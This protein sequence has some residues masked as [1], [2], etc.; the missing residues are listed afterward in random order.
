[1]E[2]MGESV[3]PG[4]NTSCIEKWQPMVS[5]YLP[6]PCCSLLTR[7]LTCLGFLLEDLFICGSAQTSAPS[8]DCWRRIQQQSDAVFEM[9]WMDLFAGL[10]V[11]ETRSDVAF[12]LW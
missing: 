9:G 5:C 11:F 3:L 8:W 1:M 10:L 12:I 6:L 4:K 2:T 7:H